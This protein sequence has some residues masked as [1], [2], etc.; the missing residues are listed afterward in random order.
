MISL[1]YMSQIQVIMKSQGKNSEARSGGRGILLRT[2]VFSGG[3]LSLPSYTTQIYLPRGA[4]IHSGLLLPRIINQESSPQT[5][6]TSQSVNGGS[7]SIDFPS[8]QKCLGL[9]HVDEN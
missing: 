6:S 8:F 2:S 5:H 3:L 1:V 7:L 4:M 9:C